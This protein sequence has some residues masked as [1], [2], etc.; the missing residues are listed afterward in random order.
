[1]GTNHYVLLLF[2][3]DNILYY[4]EDVEQDQVLFVGE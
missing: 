3:D 4:H 1:M 2:I